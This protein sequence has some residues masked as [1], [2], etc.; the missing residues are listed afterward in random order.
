[1]YRRVLTQNKRMLVVAMHLH[2]DI[3]VGLGRDAAMNPCEPSDCRSLDAQGPTALQ[4]A[5]TVIQA[6]TIENN[7]CLHF[8]F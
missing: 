6:S 4:L 5:T 1:M 8:I 7:H 2:T 3:G